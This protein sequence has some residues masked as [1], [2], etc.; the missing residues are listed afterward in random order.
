MTDRDGFDT[1]LGGLD[2]PVS[3]RP[4][5]A[6]ELRA[7]LLEELEPAPASPGE[8]TP[9]HALPP[10]REPAFARSPVRKP[11]RLMMAVEIAAALAL[12]IGAW[13]FAAHFIGSPDVTPGGP[14]GPGLAAVTQPAA[15]TQAVVATPSPTTPGPM[16]MA[17]GNPGRTGE[18]PGPAPAGT[19]SAAAVATHD[20]NR[21][22]FASVALGDTLYRVASVINGSDP[23]GGVPTETHLEARDI[24]TGDVRWSVKANVWGSPAVSDG[25][26]FVNVR[27]V[28][29]NVSNGIEAYSAADGGFLW[30]TPADFSNL[31]CDGLFDSPLV[32]NGVIYASSMSG[33]AK[34]IDAK[35]GAVL[36]TSNAAHT[37][38]TISEMMEPGVTLYT[39]GQTTVGDGYLFLINTN[40]DLAALNLKDGS[41]AW[42]INISTTFNFASRQIQPFF[43][44]GTLLLTVITT[45]TEDQSSDRVNHLIA[46]DPKTSKTR[47]DTKLQPGAAVVTM[48]ASGTQALVSYRLTTDGHSVEAYDI[49]TGALHWSY[50]G[51]ADNGSGARLAIVGDIAY[52]L[53]GGGRLVQLDAKT[54]NASVIYEDDSYANV[55]VYAPLVSDGVIVL[56]HGSGGG[57]ADLV[58][59]SGDGSA[60]ASAS[61]TAAVADGLAA[62]D[63]GDAGRTGQ[64]LGPAPAGELSAQTIATGDYFRG[65]GPAAVLGDTIYR[66]AEVAKGETQSGGMTTDPRLE[67]RDLATGANVLWSVPVRVF[68]GPA[69]ADGRVFVFALTP[70]GETC[71]WGLEAY[72]AADGSFLWRVPMSG[73]ACGNSQSP[74]VSN[75]VVYGAGQ[76]G[77]AVAIDAATGKTIWKSTVAQTSDTVSEATS[78]EITQ[79]SAGEFAIAG[80]HLYLFN[81]HGDLAA[82]NL[83]D[84][85]LAWS[86]SVA[87]RYGPITY[88]SLTATD[89]QVVIATLA[90]S[91]SNGTNVVTKVMSVAGATGDPMWDVSLHSGVEGVKALAIAGDKVVLGLSRLT[92]GATNPDL[93][94]IEAYNLKDGSSAWV[95]QSADD[96]LSPSDFAVAGTVVYFIGNQS[97]LFK[98]D[99]NTGKAAVVFDNQGAPLPDRAPA[100]AN[101]KI[102]LDAGHDPFVILS[103]DGATPTP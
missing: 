98:L 25:S 42:S 12:L 94:D 70:G 96:Q 9:M 37:D 23:G 74:I 4:R 54:G 100:I 88:L 76:N 14:T 15:A 3:P 85:S 87:E 38:S 29:G 56:D 95:Y 27:G 78:P 68:G 5:F 75:G 51:V 99:A 59:L 33:D 86:F 83:N 11:H 6:N 18:Q 92:P 64:Q 81:A 13:Q 49:A 19:L 97:T 66:I 24:A 44:D 26:V 30:R 45:K 21:G 46:I 62:M 20:Y 2:Q 1:L 17:G 32:A 10:L 65:G 93:N 60:P 35:T 102:V 34:A 82:L 31:C 71:R 63:G 50:P 90:T 77:V 79:Q 69:A 58:I 41:L 72:N 101:N 7:R 47:W 39:A 8:Q 80:G 91:V 48:A 89:D 28:G 16:T 67:A 84:G 53:I 36:W 40:A 43:T 52:A 55:A 57:D 61:P 103:G 73:L 22:G